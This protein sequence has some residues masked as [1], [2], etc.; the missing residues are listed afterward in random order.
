MTIALHGKGI[1]RG[2]ALGSSHNVH[3]DTL[4]VAE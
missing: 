3:R 1:S 2:I 4:E